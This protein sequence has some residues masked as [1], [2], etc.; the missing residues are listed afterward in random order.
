MKG[1]H[2]F[3]YVRLDMIMLKN[4]R[5]LDP[6]AKTD[7]V[8]DILI[9]ESKVARIG[10]DLYLDATLMARANGEKL[11]VKDCT[12]LCAAPGFIDVHV[13][14]R[15]PGFEYKEDISTGARAAA[16]GGFTTIVA[17]AN[18]KP[19]I[20]DPELVF[21]VLKNG[22]NTGI[23]VKTC[24]CITKGMR[25]K[26][27]ADLKSLKEAG[28]VGFT[29]DGLP[30]LDENLVREAMKLS[31]TLKMPLS[32]HEEDPKF[33]K[34][35]GINHGSSSEKMGLYGADRQAEVSMVVRDCK[36]AKETGAT[37]SIQH[38]SAKESVEAVRKAKKLGLRVFAEA[39][40]HHFS[41]TD[42]DVIQ[43]GTL[44][45]MNPPLR[46]EEDRIAIIEG[47]KDGTI[48]MIAT[49]HAPHSVEEKNRDF[50]DAPSGIIGLET[51]FSLGIMNLVNPGYLSLLELVDKMSYRP[52]KLYNLDRG[53]LR[54]DEIADIVVFDADK[55]W[56]Y[57]KSE[58][59]ST[60]SPWLNTELQGEIVYTI[61]NGNI[62]YS[63]D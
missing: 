32:F 9:S 21:D 46:E 44:A 22:R 17:M 56:Y 49:D 37:I 26:E 42:K 55:T 61:C 24:A 34:E 3:I 36:L 35:N 57:D 54:E 51:S 45:K 19:P 14:L 30:L 50:V 43:Y 59:K 38:I 39:T 6:S 8:N 11:D 28:A 41:L 53:V 60:N 15:E 4:V 52:S 16:K 48:D 10:K 31:K 25:G 63:A 29:D 62:V 18:T 40:P 33:I 1:K 5:L 2:I 27:L 12:G 20:D 47:L 58:S 23:N 7:E 13:H